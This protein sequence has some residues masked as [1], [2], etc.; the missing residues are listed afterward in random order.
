M[1][2]SP[3][4]ASLVARYGV[5][6]A[7]Q[8]PTPRQRA[9]L[10]VDALEALYGGA[11]GGGK[12][13]ALLMAALQYADRPGYSALI[14]RRTYADLALAGAIMD[15]AKE[16]L[17]PQG[18]GWNEREK[19]FRFPSGATLSFGYLETEA[20]R[21]RYQGSEYNF[22]AFDELTQFTETQYAYLLSRLRRSRD[23]DIPLRARAGSNPGG[24]GH[25]W[26]FRRFVKEPSPSRAFVPARLDDNPHLDRAAYRLSL[27]ALDPVTRRQ[28]RDGEWIQDHS[29]LVY[30][31]PPT[32]LL[33]ERPSGEWTYLLGLDFG[34]TDENAVAVLGWRQ[35]DRTVYVL[36]AY[37]LHASP[38]E[39]AEHVRELERRYKPVSIVGDTG[40]MGKA[41]ADEMSRRYNV[42][43]KAAEK[44]NK[45][46]YIS[47]L[48][49]E[50]DAGRVRVVAPTSV[51]LVEEW[52]TLAW[53]PS[54]TKPLDGMA[55][56]AS[57]S[58]LYGW[59]E[60]RALYEPDPPRRLNEDERVRELEQRL[61][62][63]NAED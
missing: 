33:D 34:I 1:A 41:F 46:G 5:P 30:R 44:H 9:F 47:L 54:R 20:D 56:H 57:D 31:L 28:L 15:R 13:S 10:A 59:R 22:L 37:R 58:V 24:P 62:E 40:G 36:E 23:S 21:L 60:A 17:I 50:L 48:N 43:I 11:A 8:L 18:I 53:H 42:P 63:E 12:S 55:D 49:G 38:S 61:W 32:A 6:Y 45:L 16:W 19:T 14:L 7:P 2:A 25:E 4:I 39:M 52:R 35:H 27:D 51:H 29:G 26:V 3:A